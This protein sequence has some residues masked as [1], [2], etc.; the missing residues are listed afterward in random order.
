M[1]SVCYVD[2]YYPFVWDLDLSSAMLRLSETNGVWRF[3][4]YVVT[5]LTRDFSFP[6]VG[7]FQS[8]IREGELLTSKYTKLPCKLLLEMMTSWNKPMYFVTRKVL[9]RLQLRNLLQVETCSIYARNVNFEKLNF[10]PH[11]N[12]YILLQQLTNEAVATICLY[13]HFCLPMSVEHESHISYT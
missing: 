3:W 8:G 9:V 2:Y 6:C 7:G 13:Y 10:G 5:L 1:A 11:K 4:V 12:D